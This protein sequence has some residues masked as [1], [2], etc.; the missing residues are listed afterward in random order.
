[1]LGALFFLRVHPRT[2]AHRTMI[3]WLEWFFPSELSNSRPSLTCMPRDL[4][5]RNSRS[6]EV[7]LVNHQGWGQ[8][9]NEGSSV[10]VKV[11]IDVVKHHDQKASLGGRGLFGLYFHIVVYH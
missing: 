3:P 2:L 1:M 7:Y 4:F 8:G 5:L 9:N 11:S 10:L 6:F